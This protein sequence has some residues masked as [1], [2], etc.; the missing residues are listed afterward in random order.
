MK[1]ANVDCD[2]GERVLGRSDQKALDQYWTE[3]SGLA[4][5][6]LM[7]QAASA[8][9]HFIRSLSECKRSSSILIVAG[10]GQNGG[11][12][13]ALARQ[14]SSVTERVQ[15]CDLCEDK[16]LSCEAETMRRAAHSLGIQAV[17]G[18]AAGL[19]SI[20]HPDI[21]VEG[22]LGTGFTPAR[23]F[24][25]DFI[26]ASAYMQKCRSKGSLIVS[27]DIPGGLD[28]DTGEASEYAVQADIT[29]SFDAL[30]KGMLSVNGAKLCGK[31]IILPIGIPCTSDFSARSENRIR[32]VTREM[33]RS[34]LPLRDAFSHKGNH[35]RGLLL[36]GSENMPGALYL[37]AESALR[38]GI[39]YL[40][41]ETDKGLKEAF[42]AQYAEVLW[43][44]ADILNKHDSDLS[45]AAAGPGW[46]RSEEKRTRLLQLLQSRL[47]LILD[48]DAL[49]LLAERDDR[50]E[51]I[52]SRSAETLLTPHPGE[53]KR[54]FPDLAEAAEGDRTE[55]C[56]AA[57]ASSGAV[58]LLKG[59]FTVLA[60]PDGRVRIVP[61]ASSALA[62][63]GS[64]DV[65]SGLILSLASQGLALFDAAA[66]AARLHAEAA[67][68]HEGPREGMSFRVG[69]LAGLIK[70][71]LEEWQ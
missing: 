54:L 14:L 61:I 12:A 59:P 69:E 11:D 34:L 22:M 60:A 50:T 32:I 57:A 7:E 20:P 23:A 6:L 35:G 70:Q 67:L 58:V 38:S 33:A 47:P 71:T 17:E 27:L 21:I 36:A 56:K 41:V 16:T 19:E 45:A 49:N 25:P 2:W 62:R 43:A 31:I 37:A 39:G 5:L 26:C 30:K 4:L 65:L 10:P 8:A 63:A 52:R 44:P 55:A 46:G 28:A 1:H 24:R 40:M 51:L 48:A 18:G 42:T 9:F 29:L 15:V 66:A 53:F 68:L 3:K 64:G 13:W